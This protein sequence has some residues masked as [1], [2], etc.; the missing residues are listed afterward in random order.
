VPLIKESEVLAAQT[1]AYLRARL[2]M[3]AALIEG[4]RGQDNLAALRLLRRR[5]REVAR[6]LRRR[7][8]DGENG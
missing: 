1:T 7:R 3:M 2:L 6:E 5:R 4:A 8:D